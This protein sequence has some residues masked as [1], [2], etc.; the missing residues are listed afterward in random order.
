MQR[1]ME[2]ADEWLRKRKASA[3]RSRSRLLVDGSFARY[4]PNR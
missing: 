1:L 3:R 4:W 2:I